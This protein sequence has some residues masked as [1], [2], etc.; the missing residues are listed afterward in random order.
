MKLKERSQGGWP[1]SEGI[2]HAVRACALHSTSRPN[3]YL[4]GTRT[5][6]CS[7]STASSTRVVFGHSGPVYKLRWSPFSSNTPSSADWTIKLWDQES[8]NAIFTFSSTTDYVADIAWS[9]NN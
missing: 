7:C 8:P 5:D 1:G 2:I 3:I 6:K 4:A 9:P